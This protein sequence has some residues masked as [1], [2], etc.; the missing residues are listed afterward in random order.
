MR[1]RASIGTAASIGLERVKVQVKPT[2]AYLMLYSDSHCLSNCMFCPQ[3]RESKSSTNQL[4]RVLWP[5]YNI[6]D[7]ISG[8]KRKETGIKR[9]CIQTVRYKGATE[10]LM[11]ILDAFS[12]SNVTLPIS[13]CS[14]PLDKEEFQQMKS[15]GVS[16]VGISFDCATPEIFDK[17]KG[18]DRGID[19]TWAFLENVIK[20]AQEV[21]GRSFVS[22]HLIIGLGETEYEA[23]K[24]IQKFY[25]QKIT[26]G[27]FAFTPIKGT[28]MESMEQ[29]D[30][31]I[32]RNIQLARYLIYSG[33]SSLNNMLFSRDGKIIDFNV[34]KDELKTI[35]TSGKPFKTTGCSH[36]NRPFYN[37]SP[38]NELYNFPRELNQIEVKKIVDFLSDFI[39]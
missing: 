19:F 11:K 3:A 33:K 32:Y 9:I 8:L 21:F 23:I 26:V 28:D 35:I 16:R 20:D 39:N 34:E 7:V 22:T 15:L 1:I 29:P 24:F 4:S 18:K 38:R 37:E 17:I 12:R 2:T 13:V 25:D 5:D 14:Y 31:R 10:D 6:D 36:C 30:L 27:L